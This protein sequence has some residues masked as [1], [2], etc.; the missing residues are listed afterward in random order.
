MA[1]AGGITSGSGAISGAG[2]TG[3]V[4]AVTY[5]WPHCRQNNSPSTG[6]NAAWQSGHVTNASAGI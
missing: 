1:G 4:W 2:S 3:W 6:S 5:T